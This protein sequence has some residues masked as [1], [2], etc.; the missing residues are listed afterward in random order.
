VDGVET[1]WDVV[2]ELDGTAGL[3]EAPGVLAQAGINIDSVCCT[4]VLAPLGCHLL[5]S[6]GGAAAAALLAAGTPARTRQVVVCV[7]QN[8]PG[9]LAAVSAALNAAGATV[10]LLYQ[11]TERGLVIG[12]HHLALVRTA[13]GSSGRL[14]TSDV[15][16]SP[17]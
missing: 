8:R 7:L 3:A 17:R 16:A 4:G 10:D 9:T 14:A 13:L 1:L 2:V 11:A 6:D 5:V 15:T 12:A